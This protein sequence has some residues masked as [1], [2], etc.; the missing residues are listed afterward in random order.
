M[1]FIRG[2]NFFVEGLFARLMYQ[3]LYAMHQRALHGTSKVVLDTTARLLTRQTEPRV[4]L[5]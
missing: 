4:K 1:G 2:K 5:H 3:S